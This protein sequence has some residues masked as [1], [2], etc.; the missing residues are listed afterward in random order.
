MHTRSSATAEKE[1][2]SYAC[3]SRLSN[4]SRNAIYWT[5]PTLYN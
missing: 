2:V 5:P 3:H 4:W 1:R